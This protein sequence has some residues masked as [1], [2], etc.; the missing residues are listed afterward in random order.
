MSF[1]HVI[2]IEP[3]AIIN[4]VM[5]EQIEGWGAKSVTSQNALE[6]IAYCQEQAYSDNRTILIIDAQLPDHDAMDIAREVRQLPN[7]MKQLDRQLA[8]A[9][10]REVPSVPSPQSPPPPRRR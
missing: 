10:N 1:A 2:I 9:E 7:G 8:K 5:V 6:A 4:R 3:N